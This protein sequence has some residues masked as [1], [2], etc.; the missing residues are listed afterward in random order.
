MWIRNIT[1]KGSTKI[2]GYV[3]K[4]YSGKPHGQ[5]NLENALVKSCNTY[6]QKGSR[7]R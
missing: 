6:L 7:S 3:L 5:M 2:D 4:D 1:D